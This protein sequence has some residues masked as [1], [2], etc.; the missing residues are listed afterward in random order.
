M[1]EKNIFYR[2]T[3]ENE[4][5]VTEVLCNLM[6][7]SIVRDALLD[8]LGIDLKCFE[9]IKFENIST[10]KSILEQKRPDFIIEN[11]ET[12]IFIENKV[13]IIAPLQES[14]I[15]IYPK[16]IKTA[17]KK[18]KYLIFL[19]PKKYIHLDE[20]TTLQNSFDFVKIIFWED[21]L[22]ML[23][24]T[25][26]HKVNNIYQEALKYIESV[27]GINANINI[28]ELE[29]III[30]NNIRDLKNANNVFIKFEAISKEVFKRITEEIP[31]QIF[32]ESF[33]REEYGVGLW[34]NIL[35]KEGLIY[36]GYSFTLEKYDEYGF[37]LAIHQDIF[38]SILKNEFE[39]YYYEN[40]NYIK[41]DKYWSCS[42]NPAGDLSKIVIYIIKK[43]LT[44]ASTL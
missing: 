34:I 23:Y 35:D 33:C 25:G 3:Q 10:Q 39:C 37:S 24:A 31:E 43:C 40:W 30:M 44:K 2:L 4:N 6:P 5:A 20:I 17:N 21:Y 38:N 9:N 36:L 8:K 22:K 13:S 26:L 41:I 27:I 1:R 11:I 42:D 14:Q 15:K 29:E 7:I 28:F 12:L 19:V 32:K 18:Y 16:E